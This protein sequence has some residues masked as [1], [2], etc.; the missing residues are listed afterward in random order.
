[1]TKYVNWNQLRDWAHKTSVE[2]GFY[3]DKPSNIHFLCLIISE[4][5]EAVEA[6]RKNHR[7]KTH[8]EDGKRYEIFSDQTFHPG[9]EYFKENFEV[10]IKNTLEDELAD[11]VIRCLDLAGANGINIP[12]GIP[13]AVS[14]PGMTF[15]EKIWF[16]VRI[17]ADGRASL[18]VKLHTTIGQCFNLAREHNI[19]LLWHIKKKMAYNSLRS[20]KH[21][22]R[23]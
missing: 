7:A 12:N 16:A 3:E 10:Y 23:Y 14:N 11:V 20:A 17:L 19:D 2:H 8:S 18:I 4:L 15:T 13:P 1:M 5:M 6:D 22:K 21:G 9:N